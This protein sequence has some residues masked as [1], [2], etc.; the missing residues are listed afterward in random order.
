M[1]TPTLEK[2]DKAEAGFADTPYITAT[3][4]IRR[5]NP[6]VSDEVQWQDFEISIDPK[7]RVLDA[8]HK[9]KWELDG[10]LTFRRSCAH[11]ICG[12]DAMRING[13][14]RL[15]CKTLIKDINPEKPITVEA[16]KGLTVLKDLVVD[17]DPFFQAYRDVMPFLI[18]KGNE[19]TRERL[20]SAEDRERFDDTTKCILCAACTSS[21]PVFWNDGQYF[22]PAAI[23]NAHRFIFDSRDEGGE[24]RLEILNDRDGVWRCRTTFNCTDACPRGI[25]V[26]KAIQEVKRALITRRF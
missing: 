7:E 24:Q 15:A 23:V 26:T 10:T 21:C 11:G 3:F 22:G 4:R 18:T 2:T 19:P 16:I 6:E 13:K 17:M 20:Q 12:S 8:L 25:E 5:F 9:I 1:A 14:N